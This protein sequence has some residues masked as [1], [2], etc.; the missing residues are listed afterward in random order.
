MSGYHP[1]VENLSADEALR[2]LKKGNESFRRNLFYRG[3]VTAE[4]VREAAVGQ[5]PYAAIVSCS[6]S[7]VIP[8]VVFSAGLGELFVVRTAG[9]VA[10]G[11][12]TLGSLE[13][14]V[15]CLGCKLIL[16][17]GH[18]GCGAI[19]QALKGPIGGNGFGIVHE[20]CSVIGDERDP[21]RMIEINVRNTMRR[22]EAGMGQTNGL[23]IVGGYYDLAT[24]SVT[25]Y[26]S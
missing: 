1:I 22:I 4:K 16:V 25:F 2:R 12:N 3:E 9:I 21:M 18:T 13:Y 11:V 26:E 7:R 10:D 15:G 8:E 24:G 5:H 20:I 6:D 14:A 23:R 19:A 17:L